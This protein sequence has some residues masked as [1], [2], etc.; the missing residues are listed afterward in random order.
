M[1]K[2][3]VSELRLPSFVEK[4]PP[5]GLEPRTWWLQVPRNY[6]RAWTISLP[7]R[8]KF[9]DL[10]IRCIVSEPS[11]HKTWRARLLITLGFTFGLPVRHTYLAYPPYPMADNSPDLST[12]VSRRSCDIL[13]LRRARLAARLLRM[14]FDLQSN[15]TAT[16]STS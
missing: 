11:R 9:S 15:F 2:R 13:I 12:T 4:A 14:K 5:R 7:F 1:Q 10:G 6:F 8:C 16:R 3:T